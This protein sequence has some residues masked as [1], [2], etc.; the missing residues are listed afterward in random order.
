MPQP[1]HSFGDG[2]DTTLSRRELNGC[3]TGNSGMVCNSVDLDLFKDVRF[4]YILFGAFRDSHH[5]LDSLSLVVSGYV[6]HV[7]YDSYICRF[8]FFPWHMFV[9]L[10]VLLGFIQS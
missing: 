9:S 8:P 5:N 1:P 7:S 2:K 4:E 3:S 10:N 6:R